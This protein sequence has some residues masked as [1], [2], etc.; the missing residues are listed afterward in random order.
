MEINILALKRVLMAQTLKKI[1]ETSRGIFF[2]LSKSLPNRSFAST[3]WD[4][5]LYHVQKL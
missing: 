4:V 5:R 1:Q 3:N 2:V